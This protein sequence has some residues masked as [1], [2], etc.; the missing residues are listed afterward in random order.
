MTSKPLLT[1]HDVWVSY[2][3]V[4]A[5][6]GATLEVR[7]GQL[8]ALIGSNGAGKSSLL[9]AIAGLVS[10]RGSV[11]FDGR[12]ILGRPAHRMSRLGIS[13]VPEGRQIF[14]GLSVQENLLIG[15]HALSRRERRDALARV[16]DI[17]PLLAERRN[18]D[19]GTLSGGQQQILAI[20]RAVM[21]GPRLCLL[22]EPSLGLAP[23]FVQM[24]FA[25]IEKLRESGL[26]LLVVEQ[27]AS[28]ILAAADRGYVLEHGR[29][30]LEGTG[31]ELLGHPDVVRRYLGTV[32]EAI[33]NEEV[34]VNE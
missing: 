12:E 17:F 15:A 8:V 33:A 6:R 26:T 27:L 21:P 16:Y 9:K 13:L 30:H 4:V 28:T 22:D 32:D 20:G 11:G 14:A 19:G 2:G 1:C 3:R 34:K 24:V 23:I 29:V 7:R 5:V 10:A 18:Q 25:E 31:R